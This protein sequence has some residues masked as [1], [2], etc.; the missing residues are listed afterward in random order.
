MED[1]G[2]REQTAPS[3][4]PFALRDER[5]LRERQDMTEEGNSEGEISKEEVD[6]EEGQG[7]GKELEEKGKPEEIKSDVERKGVS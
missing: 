6:G 5:G 4:F 2:E 1:F 7:R 3:S